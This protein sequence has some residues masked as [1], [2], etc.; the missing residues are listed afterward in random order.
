M[1]TTSVHD[2]Q[3]LNPA[4]DPGD[5]S[6]GVPGGV[7]G[8]ESGGSGPSGGGSGDAT[9]AEMPTAAGSGPAAGAAVGSGRGPVEPD[10]VCAA[11]T[12]VARAA[13]ENVAETGTVG[14]HLGVV[15]ESERLVTHL[16][17]C[18]A[19]GYRGWHW[20][21]TLARAPRS[22]TATVCETV[23]LP[24]RDA[25]QPPV[26]VPWSDRLEPGDLGASDVLPY[27]LDD[28][29]L[30]QGFEQT[31]DEEAD[32]LAVWE[33]GLGR[34][35]VLGRT[36]RDA[37]ANRWYGGSRGPTA[38]E[39]VHAAAACSTCGYFVP[40][41]GGLR[42][43]FGVCANEWSPSDG[44]VVSVDHGC[45]AH[46]ETDLER[47]EPA[48]LPEPILDELGH[49]AVEVPRGTLADPGSV[50]DETEP[51]ADEGEPVADEVPEIG[52]PEPVGEP[53]TGQ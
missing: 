10:G 15:A 11:A 24:G 3:F 37:A 9:A 27:R 7:P 19:R 51:V 21:V 5:L 8:G 52:D 39:A 4:G 45:G 49:E 14:E 30:D 34:V 33:L 22:R 48:P 31:D 20:A 53:E 16:F 13:A 44:R 26:W 32:R 1:P 38:D 2:Q 29:L 50:V 47:I 46:S 28:P 18:L 42:L 40:L 12:P 6:G 36:G 25:I 41:A 17:A 23:L 35:R 43:V